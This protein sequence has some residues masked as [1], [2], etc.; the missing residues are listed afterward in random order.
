MQKVNSLPRAIVAASQFVSNLLSPMLAPTYGV[1]LVLWCSFLAAT[2]TGDRVA[3][4]I[5]VFGITCI[6][7]M[8]FI[9]ILAFFHK[10][11]S[12]RLEVPR[13]RLWPYV[14][15]VACYVGACFY[16]DHIHAPQWFVMFGVGGGVACALCCV[17]N[18][19]WKI[20]AHACGMGG[21]VALLL[22]MH[23]Q[24]LE[25]FNLLWVLVATVLLTGLVCA[26]RMVLRSH[27][28]L[29]VLA[30]ALLGYASVMTTMNLLG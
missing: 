22:Y 18:L 9:S 24:G 11:K 1:M 3:A 14:F 6:L 29:Q 26:A 30:G 21:L 7:P 4:L 8:V 19:R 12:R 5:I 28:F 20:S 10:I 25:A 13:D 15:A 17:I 16:L 23:T 27:D 2:P